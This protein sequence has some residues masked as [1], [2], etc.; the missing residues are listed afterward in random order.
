[1]SIKTNPYRGLITASKSVVPGVTKLPGQS[2][3]FTDNNGTI[4]ASSIGDLMNQIGSALK[5]A[6][7]NQLSTKEERSTRIEAQT[8]RKEVLMEAFNDASNQSMK[9]LGEAIAAEIQ[10][11]T[12][13]EGFVRKLMQYREIGQGENNEVKLK[14]KEVI[15]FVA[16]S[17][18]QVTPIEIRQ[19]MIRPPEVHVNTFILI[20][21]GELAKSNDDILEE[22]YEEG[23]EGIMVGEDRLW[24]QMA[25]EASE[26]R[27]TLQT[28]S[29]FTPSVFAR[30]TEQV[31]RWGIPVVQCMLSST[32]WQDV[33]ANGDFAGVLDPV[34]KWELLQDGTLGS[35]YGVTITTDS[36]RQSNLRVLDPGEI[37]IV[38]APINHGVFTLRGTMLSEPVN[39][40]PQGEAKKGWF[41]DEIISMVLGNSLSVCRGYKI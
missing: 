18:S 13:R 1:M 37:F 28:F 24:K 10:E 40:F 32:L 31:S 26:V 29:T 14:Q 39:R 34:T 41:M 33:V 36:F 38:G 23:L 3:S 25:V 7:N 21:T 5:A 27:N 2:S 9:V 22:K 20:D 16:S 35:L 17:A 19:R 12:N 6:E 30:M 4:N 8:N 11:T 15:G